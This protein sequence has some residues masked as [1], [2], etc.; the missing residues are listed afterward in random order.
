MDQPLISVII[1]AYNTGRY[2][3]EA[4]ISV[5]E[6]DYKPIEVIVV[7]DGSTDNTAVVAR[8]F[9]NVIYAYQLNRGPS[10]ARNTGLAM[11]N[12]DVIAFL[13]ADDFWPQGKLNIQVARL[14]SDPKIEIVLGRIQCRGLFTAR[15]RKVRFEGPDNTMINI[16]LGSGIFKKSVFEKVGYFDETLRYYED[17]DWFLRAREHGISIVILRQIT[18]Y[19]RLHADSMSRH[20]ITDDSFIKV[21]KKSLDRRRRQHNGLVK[22]LP[23][24]F[25][26]DETK[27]FQKK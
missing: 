12:G 19:N 2:L 5:F 27:E 18:L 21:I 26:F 25:D 20:R 14:L 8:S 11:A 10:V 13:D 22:S 3:G 24:F 16:C 6:Q 9:K 7:D 4:L 15:E 23:M 1:P 17:H